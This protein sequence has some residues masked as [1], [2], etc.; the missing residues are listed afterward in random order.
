MLRTKK[1]NIFVR[2]DVK[3]LVSVTSKRQISITCFYGPGSMLGIRGEKGT[4]GVR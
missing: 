3:Y 1:R 2:I 4:V